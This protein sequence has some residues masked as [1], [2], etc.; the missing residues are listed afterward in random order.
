M[1]W[2][3]LLAVLFQGY[4]VTRCPSG[5]GMEAILG[6]QAWTEGLVPYRDFKM[7]IGPLASALFA[8]LFSVPPLAWCGVVFGMFNLLTAWGI[9]KLSR[10]TVPAAL[11]LLANCFYDGNA[12]HVETM[13]TTFG[14]WAIY[15]YEQENPFPM[16]VMLFLAILT[17]QTGLTYT[18][19]LLPFFRREDWFGVGIIFSIG[20]VCLVTPAI[21]Y[22]VWGPVNAQ[23]MGWTLHHAFVDPFTWSDRFWLP[24]KILAPIAVV[25]LFAPRGVP[26]HLKILI[27]LF[28]LEVILLPEKHFA[29]GMLPFVCILA[30]VAAKN[31]MKKVNIRFASIIGLGIFI[32]FGLTR[33]FGQTVGLRQY[34]LMENYYYAQKLR[35]LDIKEPVWTNWPALYFIMGWKVPGN[36]F[37][38]QINSN[39]PYLDFTKD[40]WQGTRTRIFFARSIDDH[41]WGSLESPSDIVYLRRGQYRYIKIYREKQGGVYPDTS[42]MKNGGV[43]GDG[44]MK[45]YG[46]GGRS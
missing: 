8:L 5:L 11:F 16:A 17:K 41:P 4:M 26:W 43:G 46:S 30:P 19:A 22:G 1:T 45:A 36:D 44:F 13:M 34:G 7:H 21:V 24:V 14:V 27:A 40:P 18:L 25:L 32:G 38:A 31:F 42:K 23:L 37:L 35:E 6:A 20:W 39:E 12:M 9:Y 10:S 33:L 28:G 2:L 29:L 15:F 3:L